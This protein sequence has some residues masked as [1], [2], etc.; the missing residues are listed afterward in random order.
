MQPEG[1]GTGMIFVM[2]QLH[3]RDGQLAR[4]QS[5]LVRQVLATRA[6][7]GCDHYALAIDIGNPNAL[8]VSERWVDQA[9]L[10]ANLVSDH[11]VQFQIDMRAVQLM[12]ASVNSY[13][14]DG[15]V[16]KMIDVNATFE[17]FDKVRGDM[18]IVMGTIG[19]APGE[20]DR[21]HDD[22]ALQIAETRAE[23]GCLHYAFARDV[24]DR[25]VIHISER[26]H[27]DSALTAHLAKPHTREFAKALRKAKLTSYDVLAYDRAG[28]RKL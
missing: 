23:D 8:I 19:C 11:V 21:L 24:I 17:K 6:D 25:D 4:L 13:H 9:S 18:V 1:W 14:E 7:K 5:A 3:V 2:G 20:I 22:I 27:D 28:S 15:S 10:A 16:R 26:W 12:R